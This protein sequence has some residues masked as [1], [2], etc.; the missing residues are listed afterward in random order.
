[1]ENVGIFLA[2]WNV[3][4]MPL[5]IVVILWYIFPCFGICGKKNLATLHST[6]QPPPQKN[7][8]IIYN[9]CTAKMPLT[10]LCAA[11]HTKGSN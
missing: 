1:M 6:P 4:N 9:Y 7:Q 3:I 10:T 11:L 8:E 2:I 5:D